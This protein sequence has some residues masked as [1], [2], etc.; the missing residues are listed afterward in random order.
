MSYFIKSIIVLTVLYVPYMFLLRKESFYRFNR[1][2]L[3][4]I[5]LL[6]LLLPFVNIP[7]LYVDSQPIDNFRSVIMLDQLIVRPDGTMSVEVA[8]SSDY[9][10]WI[11]IISVLYVIV[12]CSVL[13]Y[14][15]AHI[16][17]LHHQIHEGVL[18]TERIG[19]ATIYCHAEDV[20]P[21]SWMNSI[22]ISENDYNFNASTI[23]RHELGHVRKK[24]SLDI[25]L[26][27]ICQVIQWINPFAWIIAKSFHDVHEYEADDA[28]LRSGVNMSQ[29]QRLLIKK[30]VGSCSYS[31]ANSFNHSQLKNRIT[32]MLKKKS[33]PWM[34]TKALYLIPVAIIAISAFAT[35]VITNTIITPPSAINAESLEVTTIEPANRPINMNVSEAVPTTTSVQSLT[36]VSKLSEKDSKVQ[37]DPSVQSIKTQEPSELAFKPEP[38]DTLKPYKTVNGKKIYVNSEV[39]PVYKGG[40]EALMQFLSTN[41]KYPQLAQECGVQATIVVTFLVNEDGSCTDF[42]VARRLLTSTTM[43][44]RESEGIS[45]VIVTSYTQKEGGEQYLTKAEYEASLNAL[46]EESLRVCRL[47]PNWT[48][49]YQKGE[50]VITRFSIPITFRLR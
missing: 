22:V 17:L 1:M 27:N 50:P 9:S 32:M 49:G 7:L 19:N 36:T 46:S 8:S 25:I 20:I 38:V 4:F 48:P 2:V 33:N 37:S 30:A 5:V 23:L 44:V 16:L 12:M 47:M 28:V 18:Y 14:K 10:N 34:R 42:E 39:M 13:L 41:V 29:Y 35:P 45:D 3:I 31:F 11:H 21:F 43:E 40:M 6:S 15:V 24:H 26:V